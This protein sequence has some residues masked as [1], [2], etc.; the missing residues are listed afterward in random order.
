M[1]TSCA[2]VRGGEYTGK[3]RDDG[4]AEEQ[5]RVGEYGEGGNCP[6]RRVVRPSGTYDHIGHAWLLSVRRDQAPA[7]PPQLPR[8]SPYVRVER[9]T[10]RGRVPVIMCDGVGYVLY[11]HLYSR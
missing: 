7:R 5:V 4:A 3:I 1:R 10:I 11:I 6:R 2:G 9:M 8:L